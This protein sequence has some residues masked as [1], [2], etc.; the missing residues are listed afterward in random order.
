MNGPSQYELHIL[1]N[2]E[3]NKK[4][5]ASLGLDKFRAFIPKTSEKVE[6]KPTQRSGL[7]RKREELQVQTTTN[8]LPDQENQHQLRRSSRLRKQNPIDSLKR[9]YDMDNEDDREFRKPQR[10]PRNRENVFG[11]ISGCPVGT[12]WSTRLSC[13]NDG[14]HRPT[15]AGIHGNESDGCYSL[16]LS[17]GYEDDLDYGVCFTY[18]G[19]GGRDLKGTKANPKNLRTAPQSKDQ[20]LTR[21]NLA[22]GRNVENGNPVR[23]IRGYKLKSSFAP[24]EGYRY[25]GLYSVV[26][27]WEAR[28]LSGFIVYKF[29]LKRCERQAPPPWEQ[30]S[31][32][33]KAAAATTE[34]TAS[35]EANHIEYCSSV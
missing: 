12:T 26:K 33:K 15:V 22:L 9:K 28:G 2:I 34:T 27:Y 7:K 5:L 29:A 23:V 17:G 32:E 30:S 16:A 19:E 3:E 1:K 13:S 6:K 18:T 8:D 14:V 11:A 25:D 20:T 31:Q 4:V 21:G 10:A 35:C 24:E